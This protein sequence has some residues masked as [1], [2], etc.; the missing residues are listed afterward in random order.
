MT[1]REMIKSE[2]DLL[3]EAIVVQVGDYISFQKYRLATSD[4]T[5][6][7]NSIPDMMNSIKEGNATPLSECVDVSKIW[8]DV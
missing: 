5:T 2:I 8:A 4:D 3:P 6:Y 1:A 7:L